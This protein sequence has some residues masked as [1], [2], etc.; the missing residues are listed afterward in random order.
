MR[1]IERAGVALT[2]MLLTLAARFAFAE[3]AID[4]TDRI[5]ARPDLVAKLDAACA[6]F[7]QGNRR[8]ARL[9]RVT[10]LPLGG[11]RFRVEG[12]ASLRSRHVQTVPAGL[13]GLLGSE[14]TLFDHTAQVR[15]RGLLDAARCRLKVEAVVLE[16]DQLGLSRFLE[17]AVGRIEHIERC[18]ELLPDLKHR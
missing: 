17:G 8:E 12:E 3:R 9:R 16:N 18:R 2:L 7:C 6:R 13:G 1:R 15:A 14:V 10:V 4:I 11:E 5:R